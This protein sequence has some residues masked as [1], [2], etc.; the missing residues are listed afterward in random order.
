MSL[1]TSSSHTVNVFLSSRPLFFMVLIWIGPVDSLTSFETRNWQEF[2]PRSQA[3]LEA[4]IANHWAKLTELPVNDKLNFILALTRSPTSH[5]QV[6]FNSNLLLCFRGAF[7]GPYH[8]TCRVLDI[9]HP[10]VE[11]WIIEEFVCYP[12]KLAYFSSKQTDLSSIQS[13]LARNLR[14]WP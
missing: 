4:G 8:S 10:T 9:W 14:F 12:L 13:N 5:A 1:F 6:S 3:E 7:E 2:S 11:G